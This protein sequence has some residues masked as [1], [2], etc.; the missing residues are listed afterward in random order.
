MDTLPNK[1]VK[2]WVDN[3]QCWHF[4]NLQFNASPKY[5]AKALKKMHVKENGMHLDTYFN[6][7]TKCYF[8]KKEYS[9][10]CKPEL[11][12][13]DYKSIVKLWS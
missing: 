7:A 8:D 4:N 11:Y 1:I 6:I 3:K 10:E 9:F 5:V 12:P 2:V 13:N